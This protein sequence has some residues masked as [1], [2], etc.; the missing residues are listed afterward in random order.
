MSS[1]GPGFQAVFQIFS[2]SVIFYK[3]GSCRGFETWDSVSYSCRLHS[4]ELHKR[5]FKKWFSC[6]GNMAMVPNST[7]TLHIFSLCTWLSQGY[8]M[9]S[10]LRSW[11][12]V[13]P[14]VRVLLVFTEVDRVL[15][16]ASEIVVG[17]SSTSTPFAFIFV[18]SF[19][20]YIYFFWSV[21]QY[22][23]YLLTFIYI[24]YTSM[25]HLT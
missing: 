21:S 2:D 8:G 12:K 17:N 14:K 22:T 15:D 10:L 23:F 24:Y 5:V 7:N 16:T 19:F 9:S 13:W 11:G 3:H 25:E 20:F 6:L 1:T 4:Q 18:F